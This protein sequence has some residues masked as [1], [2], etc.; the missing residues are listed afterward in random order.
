MINVLKELS[1]SKVQLRKTGSPFVSR[2]SS[3]VEGS[4][5]S[6]YTSLAIKSRSDLEAESRITAGLS[7]TVLSRPTIPALRS[8]SSPDSRRI[9]QL[10]AASVKPRRSASQDSEPH[11]SETAVDL[12]WP[13]PTTIHRADSWLDMAAK[14]LTESM[15]N[16]NLVLA[17]SPSTQPSH[18]QS[19]AEVTDDSE[20]CD[21]AP[22][23]LTLA[24]IQSVSDGKR[25]RSSSKLLEESMDIH[26]TSIPSSQRSST[27]EY[28][29]GTGPRVAIDKRSQPTRSRTLALR[30]SITDPSQLN[31]HV[32]FLGP[33]GFSSIQKHVSFQSLTDG[34]DFVH[35]KDEERRWF[36][37][38]DND[39]WRVGA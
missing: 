20:S 19:G 26:S 5:S 22:S 35:Q 12:Q 31:P 25:K 29:S 23:T 37:E 16:R 17:T 7:P 11:L 6:K 39:G 9:G 4:P 2:I 15:Y 24:G 32:Q 8:S 10:T 27:L 33:Q 36:R 13:S 14:D 21:P 38:S 30:R 18:Q 28:R 1:S 34:N 3:A